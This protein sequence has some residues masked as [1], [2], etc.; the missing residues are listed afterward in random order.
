MLKDIVRDLRLQRDTFLWMLGIM[1]AAFAFG[2]GVALL[3]IA[4]GGEDTWFC[5]GT[6]FAM[7]VVLIFALFAGMTG[8]GM[9][10]RMCLSMGGTRKSFLASYAFRQ[11]LLLAVGYAAVRLLYAAECAL[12]GAVFPGMDNEAAFSFL[13]S[14]WCLPVLAGL[15]LLSL[16]LGSLQ[17]KFG[18]KGMI[19]FWF[20]W[21]FC[22]L[23]LP[24]MFASDDTSALGMA[25]NVMLSA[26][27]AVPPAV[28][29][30]F[31]C[32][33]AAAMIAAIVWWGMEQ[34]V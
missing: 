16:F 29:A 33:A 21:L 13:K 2:V 25:A 26:I 30:A 19:A 22:C 31:L 5:M 3:M 24:R 4:Q 14:G 27:L 11:A 20:L 9:E 18:K 7:I 32:A 1:A 6:I 23:I 12:Y 28:W 34:T 10:F 8:F 17:A 15:A